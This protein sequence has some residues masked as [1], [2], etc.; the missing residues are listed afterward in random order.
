[1]IFT[2]HFLGAL[3][4]FLILFFSINRQFQN[5]SK[6]QKNLSIFPPVK[7]INPVGIKFSVLTQ[8]KMQFKTV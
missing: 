8:E 3:W 2:Y 1:M 5:N 4:R 6:K 7:N